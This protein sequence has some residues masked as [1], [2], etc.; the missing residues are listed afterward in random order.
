MSRA[1]LVKRALLALVPL[2]LGPHLVN[3][4]SPDDRGSAK[5]GS[6]SYCPDGL[7]ISNNLG[8]R[9]LVKECTVETTVLSGETTY[10]F[11]ATERYNL[12]G[13]VYQMLD[14]NGWRSF[15]Y[16]DQGR[17]LAYS[18]D[19]D[20]NSQETYSYDDKGRLAGIK[21]SDETETFE[22][23]S[24]GRKTRTTKPT[25]AYSP[26]EAQSTIYGGAVGGIEN[27]DLS[28]LPPDHGLVKT[29]F[30][31]RDQAVE[32]RVYD[33]DGDLMSRL[34]FQYDSKG[35]VAEFMRYQRALDFSRSP[36]TGGVV[37]KPQPSGN[38]MGELTQQI[39]YTYDEQGRVVEISVGE[40]RVTKKM[41]NE[42]GDV[43]EEIETTSG[44]LAKFDP[45][46]VARFKY[47]YDRFG[48]WV[49]RTV[50]SQSE[51]DQTEHTTSITRRLI[52][53]Y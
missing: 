16:D 6:T 15:T 10:R 14:G 44:D 28:V 32:S 22:Y 45:S 3:G 20:P 18:W 13:S 12:D 36:A 30:N 52:T 8:L 25:V 39:A 21:G 46:K 48:N 5:S 51:A 19:G 29:L 53:Y 42:Y 24:L 41:Y 17:R 11:V 9:G 50:S 38:P 47:E 33:A 23:D 49:E 40:A 1:V 34:V 7:Y 43:S 31:E 26:E 2:L 4:G 35:R 37:A 27:S